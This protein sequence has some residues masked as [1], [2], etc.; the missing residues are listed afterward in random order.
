[1]LIHLSKQKR[2]KSIEENPNHTSKTKQQ[3][4]HGN[5]HIIKQNISKTKH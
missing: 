2:A 1:M 5:K 4:K 3:F